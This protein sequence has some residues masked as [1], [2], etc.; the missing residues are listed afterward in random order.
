MAR[1]LRRKSQA[2]GRGRAK[3]WTSTSNQKG[4]GI[5]MFARAQSGVQK[6]A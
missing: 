3:E 6:K 5:G 4:K 2:S 1:N